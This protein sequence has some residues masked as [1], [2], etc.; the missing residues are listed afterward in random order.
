VPAGRH[1]DAVARYKCD[2]SVSGQKEDRI[3]ETKSNTLRD[4]YHVNPWA[5]HDG[6]MAAFDAAGIYTFIDLDTF[7]TTVVQTAPAW[8]QGQFEAYAMVMDVFSK[9]DNMAGFYI[10]NEVINSVGDPTAAAPY[11]KV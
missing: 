11:I 1:F 5:N 2:Q 3:S 4:S 9:Y 8:T 10:G 6:C 7:N